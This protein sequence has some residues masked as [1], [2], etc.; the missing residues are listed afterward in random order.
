MD[1]SV[2]KII[3]I[4]NR[5]IHPDGAAMWLYDEAISNTWSEQINWIEGG[6]GGL[7]LL[8]H[9]ETDEPILILDFMGNKNNAQLFSLKQILQTK[10]LNYD[11]T[12]ALQYLLHSLPTLYTTLPTI[13][14]MSCNPD[15]KDWKNSLYQSINQHI[16]QSVTQ[17]SYQTSYQPISHYEQIA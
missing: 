14:V 4:G 15:E 12:N 11:H 10:V 7:N 16:N 13:D 6:L 5:Y 8:P 9:F 1:I 3:C 2:V 17:P